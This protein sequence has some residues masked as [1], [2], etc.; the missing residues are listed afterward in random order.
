MGSEPICIPSYLIKKVNV[1]SAVF[2]ASIFPVFLA[3]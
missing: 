3:I 2:I 1:L